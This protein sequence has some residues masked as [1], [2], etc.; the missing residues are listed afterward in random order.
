MKKMGISEGGNLLIKANSTSQYMC[1]ASGNLPQIT[2]VFIVNQKQWSVTKAVYEVMSW[3]TLANQCYYLV[4]AKAMVG[5]LNH[6]WFK[7]KTHVMVKLKNFKY[8]KK[9]FN[10]DFE[11]KWRSKIKQHKYSVSNNRHSFKETAHAS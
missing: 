1:K 10:N 4:L 9:G 5:I 6:C 2:A 11:Q 8:F 3:I 7:W